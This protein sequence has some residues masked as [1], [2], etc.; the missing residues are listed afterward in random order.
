MTNTQTRKNLFKVLIVFFVFYLG[1]S[2]YYFKR[3]YQPWGTCDTD[4]SVFTN[5]AR[6]ISQKKDIYSQSYLETGR[7][8]Y[9]YSPAFAVLMIPLSALHRH[10]SVPIWYLSIFV[11]FVLSIFLIQ[12][13]L[14]AQDSGRS[15][16]RTFFALGILM[17]LRALLSVVQRV[18]SDCLVLFLLSLF[19]F[20]LFY[21]K[22]TLAGF[23][24]ASAV[25]VKLTPL[26]FIP[27]LILRKKFKA[28]FSAC[29]FT[30]FYLFIPALYTGYGRNLAY[31]KDWFSVHQKNPADY[32]LWYKNQ[33]LLSCLSRFLSKDS[34]LS[35]AG[36]TQTQVLIIFISLAAILF[37]LV[38]AT[39][40]RIA[41]SPSA[42]RYLTD[43][44]LI[45]ILMIIL[46]PLAWKHTFVHLLIPHFVLLYYVLYI[47]PKDKL[48]KGL[49]ISSFFLI[50]VLNPELTKPFA[51]TI[52]LLSPVTLGAILLYI[53]LLRTRVFPEN[54]DSGSLCK[55]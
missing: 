6:D 40:S 42:F 55:S 37:L 45:L 32:F 14:T 27:F 16:S 17:T 44:S 25:M 3:I 22:N 34:P 36:L 13:I 5:A 15:L 50:T 12:K 53:A 35:I 47:N 26:I 11:F 51:Q 48:S 8:F 20:A 23:A 54:T 52:Q 24:L 7:D 21:K 46:S 29:F 19:I 43:I 38:F 10:I 49:L 18:Q 4:F 1:V 30:L 28:M 41:S 33:S 2:G 39:R 31:L 9:K